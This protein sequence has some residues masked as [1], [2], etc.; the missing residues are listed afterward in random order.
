MIAA[1][2]LHPQELQAHKHKYIHQPV[3][4]SESGRG[5]GTCLLLQAQQLQYNIPVEAM[6][7]VATGRYLPSVQGTH[8]ALCVF[9]AASLAVAPESLPSLLVAHPDWLSR[10]GATSDGEWRMG[11]GW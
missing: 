3:A 2:C 9:N 4:R 8:N 1:M 10:G 11:S 7:M 5:D 6:T